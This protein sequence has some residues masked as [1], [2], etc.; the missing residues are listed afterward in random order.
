MKQ[1]PVESFFAHVGMPSRFAIARTSRFAISPSGNIDGRELRLREL[2]QEVAL[3]LGRVG[4][5]QELHALPGPSQPRVVAGRDPV[6][7]ERARVIEEGAELDLAVAEHVRVRRAARFVL[8][9]E[10]RE[11]PFAVLAREVHGLELD[12]DHVGHRRRV[13]QVDARR[14]VFVGVVVLPVLHEQADDLEA[15][16]LQ[17]PRRDGRV[18]AARH[19]DDHARLARHHNSVTRSSGRRTPAT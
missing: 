8:A 16:L 10:M 17:E 1:I 6:G 9:Q 15:L 19:A 13:D 3:V 14:A 2:V 11:D 12:A 18:D 4:G 5:L 7:A